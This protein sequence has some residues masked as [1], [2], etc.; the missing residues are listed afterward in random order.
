MGGLI[1][2][3]APRPSMRLRTDGHIVTKDGGADHT[4]AM[5]ALAARRLPGLDEADGYVL[6]GRS[7]SCGLFRLPRYA[8]DRPG[9]RTDDQPVDREGRD[10]FAALLVETLPDLPVEENGRLNDPVLREHFIERLF[11]QA[12]LRAL[13]TADWQPRDLVDFHA[14]HKMQLLAHAPDE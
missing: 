13:F 12:R 5:S 11:A 1:G 10:V 4:E 14:R 3:G 9:E 8:S 6:K 7:P 2:L